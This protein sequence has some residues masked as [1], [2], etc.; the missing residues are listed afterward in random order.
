M[1]AA[2]NLIQAGGG[3]LTPPLAPE[4]VYSRTRPADWL[5][6]PEPAAGEMY[7]LLHIPAGGS[8]LCAFTV[9][10]SG[11][12]TVALGTAG[13]GAFVQQAT[14]S[15]SPGTAWEGELD[16]A[17]YGSETSD[18]M[19][20][21]VIKVSGSGI[22]SWAPSGH[23][24]RAQYSN[25]NIV[26]MRCRLPEGA[27]LTCGAANARNALGSLR[28][29]SW[30]G[31]TS[32]GSGAG[33]FRNCAA[34]TAVTGLDV[35]GVTDLSYMFQ[36]CASLLAIPAMDTSDAENL[37]SMFHGCS[38]LPAVPALDLSSAEDTSGMFRNCYSLQ[39]IGE[40]DIQAAENAQY[41]FADC[42]SLRGVGAMDL[43]SAANLAYMFQNCYA[44][45]RAG[46]LK[47]ASATNVGSMF[48]QCFA[49][50]EA[51][52]D[53]AVTG[54][55]GAALSFANCALGHGAILDLIAS[56]PQVSGAAQLG[57][58]GNPGAAELTEAEKA[59]A[60]AKGWSV[61]A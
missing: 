53:A 52:L 33:M 36:N 50:G 17:D 15:V 27:Q 13:G 24:A 42:R 23:S 39:G 16:G 38:A 29:L 8:A 31:G 56:L 18:G 2:L 49:L 21:A 40:L 34:L 61:S 41:M 45:E 51:G 7:L 12:Y 37:S 57:L 32:A 28:Y 46:P 6:L 54:W 26:E 3:A 11:N 19:R 59:T 25:W 60:A 44:L 30:E 22:T 1:S 14:E 47:M 9:S 4:T 43:S 20:Q 48:L 58:M 35:A 55:A 10:C 5:A